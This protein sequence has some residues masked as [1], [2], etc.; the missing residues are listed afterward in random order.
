VI[1]FFCDLQL[2]DWERADDCK[3]VHRKLS[4]S[5]PLVVG[6]PCGNVPSIKELNDLDE[7]ATLQQRLEDV[8]M[9]KA[10]LLQT[11]TALEGALDDAKRQIKDAVMARRRF[12][13]EAQAIALQRQQAGI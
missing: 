2:G 7:S 3:A 6:I 10:L 12:Q 9:R 5:C 13:A 8:L 4:P 1:C 11:T